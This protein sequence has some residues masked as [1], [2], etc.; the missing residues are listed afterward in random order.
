MTQEVE[1]RRRIAE[2]TQ[3][4]QEA[5]A[6]FKMLATQVGTH[7]GEEIDKFISKVNGQKFN[8]NNWDLSDKNGEQ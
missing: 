3:N 8:P 5:V 4:Q 2:L 6:L 1:L 7:Y